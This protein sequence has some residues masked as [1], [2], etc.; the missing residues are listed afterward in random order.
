MKSEG[1]RTREKEREEAREEGVRVGRQ[2]DRKKGGKGERVLRR[3]G[4]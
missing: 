1:E 3:G 4:E 2:E